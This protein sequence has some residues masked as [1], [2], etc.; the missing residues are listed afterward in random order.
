MLHDEPLLTE[1]HPIHLVTLASQQSQRRC[2]VV[3]TRDPALIQA[4]AARHHAEP[5]TG[6]AS[7]SGRETIVVRDGGAGIRFNFPGVGRYRPIEWDEWLEHFASHEL[8]FV[9]EEP[10]AVAAGPAN[11]RYRLVPTRDLQHVLR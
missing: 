8:T 2:G 4:W 3:A 11:A 1:W 6:E 5:A 9:F 7:P 10:E